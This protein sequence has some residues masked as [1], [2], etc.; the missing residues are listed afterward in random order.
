MIVFTWQSGDQEQ[1]ILSSGD[2]DTVVS[3][4]LVVLCVFP[5]SDQ[6]LDLLKFGEVEITAPVG[7]TVTDALA[8]SIPHTGYEPNALAR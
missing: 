5:D 8:E 6:G 2:M 4:I 7:R 1:N 3:C